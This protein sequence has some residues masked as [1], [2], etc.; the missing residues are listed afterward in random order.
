MESVVMSLFDENK[1]NANIQV[2]VV[3]YGREEGDV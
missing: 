2:C 3:W 1:I